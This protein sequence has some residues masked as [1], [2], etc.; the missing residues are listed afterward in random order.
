MATY[1]PFQIPPPVAPNVKVKDEESASEWAQRW[2]PDTAA[3]W[4]NMGQSSVAQSDQL[5]Q[6]RKSVV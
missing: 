1:N 2:L 5:M 3:Y 6:D 4:Q